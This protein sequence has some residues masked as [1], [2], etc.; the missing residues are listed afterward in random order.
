VIALPAGAQCR[1]AANSSFF[2]Y[3]TSKRL[4]IKESSVNLS[5]FALVNVASQPSDLAVSPDSEL[6]ALLFKD[7]SLVLVFNPKG[8]LVAKIEEQNGIAGMLWAPDSVQLLLFSEL[9]FRVSIYD[10]AAKNISYI[11]NPKLPSARGCVF[12]SAG[13]LMALL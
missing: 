10:L 4:E 5:N 1:F 9:L 8:A 12:S 2:A 7:K 11:R 13:K 3:Y 6:I